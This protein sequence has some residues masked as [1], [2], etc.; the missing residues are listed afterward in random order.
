M[1]ESSKSSLELV[2]GLLE[3]VVG[4]LEFAV[5]DLLELAVSD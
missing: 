2:V 4:L 3:L 5:S 1:S